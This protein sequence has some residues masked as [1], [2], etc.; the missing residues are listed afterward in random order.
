MSNPCHPAYEVRR[1]VNRIASVVLCDNPGPLE[2]DGTN[3]WLLRA[4][5]APRWVVV[6]PGPP[7]NPAHTAA[8][9]AACGGPDAIEAIL[10]THRHYD[11]TG[12]LD[13]L[14]AATGAPARAWS[15]QWCRGAAPLQDREIVEL[16]GLRLVVLPTP[17]HTADSVCL[18]ADPAGERAMVAGDT[19]LGRSTPLLDPEDGSLRDYLASLEMLALV[20]RGCSVLPGHGPEL[21]A[22]VP[23][24]RSYL[25]HRGDRLDAIRGALATLGATA[26]DVEAEAVVAEVYAD[27]EPSLRPAALLT[28]RTHLD[29]LA[30]AQR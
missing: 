11:H 3:T 16:A 1:Q 23:V 27:L 24:A 2:G 25:K 18:L 22:L 14:V 28:V 5:G 7:A 9:V 19:I 12:G 30:Q 29:F 8:V 4:P 10:V 13:D 21:P 17:G 20:G 15:A 6:D 26:Q